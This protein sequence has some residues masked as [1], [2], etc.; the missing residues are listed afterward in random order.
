MF[1]VH[2]KGIFHVELRMNRIYSYRHTCEMS[3]IPES[4][5]DLQALRVTYRLSDHSSRSTL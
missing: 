2:V 1:A 4:R 5:Q 3:P